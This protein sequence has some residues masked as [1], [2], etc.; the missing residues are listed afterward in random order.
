MRA[1]REFFNEPE[2]THC[3]A[4]GSRLEF[5]SSDRRRTQIGNGCRHRFG[6]SSLRPT[7]ARAPE[8]TGHADHEIVVHCEMPLFAKKVGKHHCGRAEEFHGK[9]LVTLGFE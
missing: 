1:V 6:H 4:P 3:Q 5:P 9:P 8:G 2:A 7:P